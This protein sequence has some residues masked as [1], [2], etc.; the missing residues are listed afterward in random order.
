[1][2]TKSEKPK[3]PAGPIDVVDEASKAEVKAPAT[4]IP[5]VSTATLSEKGLTNG[6]ETQASQAKETEQTPVLKTITFTKTDSDKWQ[7]RF[8]GK[9]TRR[10]VNRLTRS[11][12]VE[13]NRLKRRSRLNKRNDLRAKQ[14]AEVKEQA[15]D[16]GQLAAAGN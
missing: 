12:L 5:A 7:V 9:V 6:K 1:M 13:F 10:D 14:V 11:M 3:S 2:E 16:N 4:S 15:N 8:D